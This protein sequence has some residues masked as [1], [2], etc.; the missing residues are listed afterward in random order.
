MAKP[1]PS[2]PITGNGFG[3]P[4]LDALNNL[5]QKQNVQILQ[6]FELLKESEEKFRAAFKTSP[7]SINLNRLSDGMYVEINAGFTHLTGYTWED[8]QDKTSGDINIWYEKADRQRMVS[9]LKNSGKAVNIEARFRLKNGNVKTGLMSASLF[10]FRNED[11]ILSVTRDITEI[12]EARAN[13]RETD[14]RFRQLAEN[15]DDVFWLSE[16][17]IILYVNGAIERKF[18]YSRNEFIN[19]VP[20]LQAII[21]PEDLP[22]FEELMLIKSAKSGD[23]IARQLRVSDSSGNIRWVWVRLFPIFD[24]NNNPY[25]VA[26]IASDI[27]VQKE[28]ESELRAAKEK[29]QESD[30]LKSSFLANLSHEIRT[31]MNGIIGFSG[32][33]AR[34]VPNNPSFN[35]YVEIIN[36]CS[37]QLLHIID[38]LVDISKIEAN[39]MKL[40]EQECN[41]TVMM[42]ELAVIY[43]HELNKANKSFIQLLKDYVKTGGAGDIIIT[44]EF[45]LRQVMM[46]LLSNAV[47]FTQ[48]GSIRFGFMKVQSDRIRFFVEDTGIGIAEKQLET[49]F[50]PFHQV[51]NKGTKL[52]GGT[53]LGLSISRGLVRLMGGNIWVESLVEKGSAFYFEIP[54]RVPEKYEKHVKRIKAGEK[55]HKFEG[56]TILIVEDDDLNYAFLQEILSLTGINIERSSDGADAVEK[57]ISLNPD[58]IVMDVRLPVLNGLDATRKIRENGIKIP[59]IAQTAYAMS[60]DKEKCLEAGCD[61]YISKPIHKE[62]LLKKIAYH[63]HKKEF[64]P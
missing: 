38:D 48:K 35:Q 1:K 28:I 60:E 46:N 20:G 40:N 34:E 43:S 23:H 14:E 33:L 55:H 32:L 41:I 16:N 36:N 59:V 18:G 31:P 5:L 37:E 25:R 2:G 39:Q 19:K 51:E 62:L 53:G 29:A 64:F 24:K 12:V 58:L 6:T 30:H 3:D 27:T 17:N 13:L 47:K 63:I 9:E 11:Y 50:K 7:D 42:D 44:D 15:I 52:Y 26:G 45:R 21:Y 61:D 54:F 4:K 49:V 57:A 56:K 22:V 10:R 8:V